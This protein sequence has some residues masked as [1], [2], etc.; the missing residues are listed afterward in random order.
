M[1]NK[2]LSN[3]FNFSDTEVRTALGKNDEP[4]F[5]AKDVCTIGR[6]ERIWNL[7]PKNNPF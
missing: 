5:C 3:P 4:L 1:S 6:G 2:I 7:N